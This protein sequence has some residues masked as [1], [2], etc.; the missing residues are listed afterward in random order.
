MF[1]YSHLYLVLVLRRRN[2]LLDA[3]SSELLAN[4]SDTSPS[5]EP[6]ASSSG[7]SDPNYAKKESISPIGDGWYFAI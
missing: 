1:I 3:E 2:P 7:L 4:E 6:A 5:E